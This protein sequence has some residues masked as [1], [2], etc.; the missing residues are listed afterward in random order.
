MKSAL[1]I[2]LNN[3]EKS[4]E[5]VSL[6]NTLGFEVVQTLCFPVR[7]IN[8]KFYLGTGQTETVKLTV[9]DIEPDIVCF[10]FSISPLIMRNLENELECT[11]M[12]REGVIL[13]IFSE[14]AATKEARL[15]VDL[16]R[17]IYYLPRQR[18]RITEL[19]QQRGGVRG[20]KGE[21]ERLLELDKRR[22]NEEIFKIR[23]QLEEV[24]K[25]RITQQKA[26]TNN[27]LFY[28]ALVGYTNVGKS[29]LL[30]KLTN[31]GVLAENK[32]FATLDPTTKLVNLPQGEKAIL[33]DTVGFVSNLPHLLID[34]FKS[35]LEEATNADALIIMLDA[36]HKD[37]EKCYET[38]MEVLT[39]LNAT[40]KPIILLL[41]KVDMV[42]D[43]LKLHNV[44]SAHPN[45]ILIS[46]KTGFNL[47]ILISEMLRLVQGRSETLLLSFPIS[48]DHLI[49]QISRDGVILSINY[50]EDSIEVKAN[51]QRIY[52]E[53][54]RKYLKN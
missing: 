23:K 16:A 31:A 6:L 1:L 17:A 39:E 3:L 48:E 27:N 29:S 38:T 9:R 33:S 2:V 14:R 45:A 8:P 4:E 10:D 47:D 51:I 34:A 20:S 7:K 50:T 25:I 37:V 35:T 40:N 24:K 30:N 15:Q 12:D 5:T 13:E 42:D 22:L 18:G 46:V 19:N 11:I 36:S 53:K 32:L 26:R 49:G 52:Y 44:K 21:G 28:F 54:Y 43:E 41:N